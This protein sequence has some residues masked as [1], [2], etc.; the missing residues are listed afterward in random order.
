MEELLAVDDA[1]SS[2][3]IFFRHEETSHGR[4]LS[5]QEQGNPLPRALAFDLSKARGKAARDGGG[6]LLQDAG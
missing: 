2:A 5:P 4:S 3:E 6:F 1:A